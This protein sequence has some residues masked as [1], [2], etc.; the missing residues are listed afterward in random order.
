M[1]NLGLTLLPLKQK[2]HKEL[3]HPV[4]ITSLTFCTW[5]MGFY[6]YHGQMF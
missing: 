3:E 4:L 5:L 1:Y 2:V 6:D